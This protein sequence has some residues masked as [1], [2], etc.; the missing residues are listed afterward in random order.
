M[1]YFNFRDFEEFKELF[2]IT[3]HGN[4]VKSRKNKIMLSLWKD[5]AW[6]KNHIA[7]KELLGISEQMNA[8][9][10]RFCRAMKKNVRLDNLE[11][12]YNNLQKREVR[13]RRK[14]DFLAFSDSVRLKDALMADLSDASNIE[15]VK[16]CMRLNGRVFWSSLY[17]T[18]YLDG[19][20]EDGTLNAI[21]Y[22][23]VEK[24]RAFKM[25]AGKM[26][27][28]LISCN[29]VLSAMPEQIK[30]WLSEEFVAEWQEYSRK[31]VGSTEYILCVDD[32]FADI[33][34]SKHCAGYDED[35]NSFGSCMVNDDQWRFYK[36]AV[37]A[38]AA[39]LKGADG[40]I[41]ARCI[42]FTN[43]EDEDGKRWRLAERQYS[44]FCKPELQRQLVSALIREGEIDGYKKI[45]A[46]CGAS[47]SFIDNDGNSLADKRF[48]IPCHLHNGDTL[49]YQD[50]FKWYDESEEVANNYG[51]GRCCLDVTDSEYQSEDHENDCWSDYNDEWIDEDDAY[52]VETRS[53]YFFRDQVV[54]GYVGNSR[55]EEWLFEDDVI[56]IDGTYY[57]AGENCD[58]PDEYDIMHCP[59]CGKWFIPGREY[60]EYSELLEESYCCEECCAEAERDFKDANWT[61]SEYDDEYFE[62]EDEVVTAFVWC[63][64]R[65]RYDKQTISEDTLE[66]LM[67]RGKAVEINGVSYVDTAILL[68][69][70]PAHFVCADFTAA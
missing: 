21:R 50:S 6:F 25:K 17:T 30:R 67:E 22:V 8:V 70:E 13:I 19:L 57:Y 42:V 38:K 31:H 62:D 60:S 65:R 58:S 56:E 69:G 3:V 29:K 54:E 47:R 44:K 34:S 16:H 26:F 43:V 53:D 7:Q 52:W 37:D 45:G 51:E 64:Y 18:D 48:S 63:R 24:G 11:K 2:G 5:K 27:N 61:Y 14:T 1:L 35:G 20:C 32:N 12:L 36:D 68:D 39:Y 41:Y 59:Y 55:H 66:L 28:H 15:G 40:L 33:Y 46:S 4:G 10:V 23:N 49:S 9:S